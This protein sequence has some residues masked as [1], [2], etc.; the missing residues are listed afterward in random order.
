MIFCRSGRMKTWGRNVFDRRNFVVSSK[1]F[2]S[3]FS[4]PGPCRKAPRSYSLPPL[5]IESW[6]QGQ[7]KLFVGLGLFDNQGHIFSFYSLK[8]KVTTIKEKHKYINEVFTLYAHF[9]MT[10]FLDLAN[11]KLLITSSAFILSKS[12]FSMP[13][14]AKEFNLFWPLDERSWFFTLF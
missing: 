7:I 3:F 6:L 10:H 1:L 12:S 8:K 11:A 2:F 5:L 9:Q 13:S 4:G 14:R